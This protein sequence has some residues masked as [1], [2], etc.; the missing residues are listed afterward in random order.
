MQSS[1]IL[2]SC[3]FAT[4]ERNVLIASSMLRDD[5][6]RREEGGTGGSRMCLIG[7]A[8]I[9]HLLLVASHTAVFATAL[10]ATE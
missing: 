1:M 2:E 7:S 9:L 8:A 3:S 4:Q 5:L 10:L 6:R